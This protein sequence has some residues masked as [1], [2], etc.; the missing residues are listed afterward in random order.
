M[1]VQRL[2]SW[3]RAWRRVLPQPR[4]GPVYLGPHRNRLAVC[5][6]RAGPLVQLP[7]A[8]HAVTHPALPQHLAVPGHPHTS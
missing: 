3:R 6:M 8:R 5:G 4:S 2:A 7:D 1:P